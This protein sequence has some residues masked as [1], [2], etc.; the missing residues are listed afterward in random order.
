MPKY[1][2]L[3]I[4]FDECKTIS[5]SDLKKWEYLNFYQIKNGVITWSRQGQKTGSI[6][7][8]TNTSVEV[9]YL[10]LDY[11]YQEESR[12][13]K[14]NIVQVPSN[15]G[16]GFINYFICPQ[17]KKRC[18]KLYLVS[19]YFLHR[20]AFKGCYYEKQTYSKNNRNTGKLYELY[21]GM[22]TSF[23]QLY[24]KHFKKYYKGKPTK[25]YLKAIKRIEL[26][27]RINERDL[28]Y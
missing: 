19:G 3:P 11:K 22:E 5:I 6:S 27:K 13:Y 2:T 12:N 9:S 7:I 24:S 21:F 23:H 14:V 28:V 10:E 25:K 4:L 20:N 8:S 26:G 15:L 17:T 18:R 16:K 1:A